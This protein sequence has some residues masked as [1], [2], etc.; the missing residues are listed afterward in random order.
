MSHNAEIN[1]EALRTT[2]KLLLN[3]RKQMV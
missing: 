3:V 2:A 1:Q